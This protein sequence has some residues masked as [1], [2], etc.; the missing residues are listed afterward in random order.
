M[1]K[2]VVLFKNKVIKE[3]AIGPQGVKIGRDPGTLPVSV[4][5]WEQHV[6]EAGPARVALLAGYAALGVARVMTILRA[7]VD[8]DEALEAFAADARAAGAELG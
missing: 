4:H 2:L 8:T 7:S 3:V 5:M 1:A 6:A